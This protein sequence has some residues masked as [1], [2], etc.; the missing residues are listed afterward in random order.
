M[1]RK[2]ALIV[3][4]MACTTPSAIGAQGYNADSL[5]LGGPATTKAPIAVG[6]SD[7]YRRQDQD[8]VGRTADRHR[9][10]R[11]QQRADVFAAQAGGTEVRHVEIKTENGHDNAQ[12]VCHGRNGQYVGLATASRKHGEART[13]WHFTGKGGASADGAGPHSLHDALSIACRGG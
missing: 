3:L 8:G 2:T 4:V 10:D 7:T 5:F 13:S 1:R 6:T 11:A 9:T 12:G